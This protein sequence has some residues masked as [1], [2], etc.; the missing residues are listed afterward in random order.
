MQMAAGLL[1][2]GAVSHEDD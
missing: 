2:N 1:F